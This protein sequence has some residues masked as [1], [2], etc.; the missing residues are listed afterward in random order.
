MRMK[1]ERRLKREA[2]VVG[3]FVALGY[4]QALAWLFS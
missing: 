3:V 2:W 4:G 1:D